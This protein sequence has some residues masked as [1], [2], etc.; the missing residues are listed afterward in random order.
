MPLTIYSI[1]LPIPEESV[2][3]LSYTDDRSLVEADVIIFDPDFGDGWQTNYMSRHYQGKPALSA[4]G[5]SRLKTAIG[6]WRQELR[7]ALLA[8]RTLIILLSAPREVFVDTGK[9]EHSGTGRNRQTTML[10]TELSSL[11]ALPFRFDDVRSHKGSKF[12]TTEQLAE[13]S[14]F[15]REF[16]SLFEYEA[17]V[18]WKK[19]SAGVVAAAG[20]R[21]LAGIAR[22]GPG[23]VVLLPMVRYPESYYDGELEA[24]GDSDEFSWTKHGRQH[25]KRFVAA[26]AALHKQLRSSGQRTPPP[27]WANDESFRG[28]REVATL[29][30]LNQLQLEVAKLQQKQQ[31]LA[32]ELDELG[33]LR[34]LV[35]EQGKPLEAAILSALRLLGFE[36]APYDDGES[37]FDALFTSPEGAFLGEAEGKD[38][39]AINVDK[40]RQLES[41]IQ[42]DF[43]RDDV[44]EHKRGVL[45]GNAYRL[46]HPDERQDFF[47]TKCLKGVERAGI[48][49]VRTTD[50]FEVAS[51]L[52]DK[53]NA[54]FARKCRRA[55]LDGAGRVVTFPSLPTKKGAAVGKEATNLEPARA[56]PQPPMD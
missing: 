53:K 43:A 15:W 11:E 54:A 41:N 29:Q 46:T 50:L 16:S 33:L 48:S 22:I 31:D 40:L 42:E 39:K 19:L 51:Y 8:G 1:G 28:Q 12:R 36:A 44:Q 55:I 18:E 35:F 56:T 34:G 5:S 24:A 13:L 20:K 4:L 14:T 3:Q 49:L 45:F 30:Q 23:N 21:A 52:R 9:R 27:D 37:E 10:L 38:N 32:N 17:S 7:D 2:E 25:G 47:T 26:I 6:F